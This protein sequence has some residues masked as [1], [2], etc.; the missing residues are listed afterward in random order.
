MEGGRGKDLKE[1]KYG[2][3]VQTLLS[4]A[5]QESWLRISMAA[6]GVPKNS[7]KTRTGIYCLSSP[8][9]SVR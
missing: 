2:V 6:W 4:L 7:K 9:E 1:N 3:L 5:D 8:W